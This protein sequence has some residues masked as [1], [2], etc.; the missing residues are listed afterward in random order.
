MGRSLIFVRHARKT[1]FEDCRQRIFSGT[2]VSQHPRAPSVGT[3]PASSLSIFGC[4]GN[5]GNS[6]DR[7]TT[8]GQ[9]PRVSENRLDIHRTIIGWSDW[10]NKLILAK[11][12]A[13]ITI[14]NHGAVS[15][16]KRARAA[17]TRQIQ[18]VYWLAGPG[19]AG[20]SSLA[21]QLAAHRDLVVFH[22]DSREGRR[23][24]QDEFEPFPEGFFE[25]PAAE[26]AQSVIEGWKR[27][28]VECVEI[29]RR[30][31]CPASVA[32]GVFDL[33]TLLGFSTA[34]RIVTIV[35]GREFRVANL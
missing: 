16:L 6:T 7:R 23:A 3:P 19:C 15:T 21:K 20:K 33:E 14:C 9:L 31:S 8:A 35:A 5:R 25:Q 27:I 28:T 32:E 2:V 17:S 26:I 22:A 30:G 18:R 12:R 29:L 13:L 11:S 1:C 34:E 24:N 10:L 4:P